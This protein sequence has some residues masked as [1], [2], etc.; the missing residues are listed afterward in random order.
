MSRA[1]FSNHRDQ[2]WETTQQSRATSELVR[3]VEKEG[4]GTVAVFYSCEE[5]EGRTWTKHW[6]SM[7]WCWRQRGLLVLQRECQVCLSVCLWLIS[8]ISL[9]CVCG[10]LLI[11]LTLLTWCPGLSPPPQPVLV[12]SLVRWGLPVSDRLVSESHTYIVKCLYI[13]IDIQYVYIYLSIHTVR[14][15]TMTWRES[16]GFSLYFFLPPLSCVCL[17]FTQLFYTLHTLMIF[18]PPL[19]PVCTP[20][21]MPIV[22]LRYL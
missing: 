9:T 6:T 2:H 4:T 18:L 12:R 11:S 8:A 17:G 21:A 14:L 16:W 7:D 5:T 1:A 3:L 19:P 15:C 20:T 22:S 13:Y 10:C